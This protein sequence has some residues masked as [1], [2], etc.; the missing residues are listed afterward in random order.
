MAPENQAR[1]EGIMRMLEAWDN[2]LQLAATESRDPTGS[3]DDD[4]RP[5]AINLH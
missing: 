1:A 3:F 2:D 4:Y 5:N